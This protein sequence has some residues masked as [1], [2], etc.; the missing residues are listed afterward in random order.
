MLSGQDGVIR[1]VMIGCIPLV[2]Q[3]LVIVDLHIWVITRKEA[4]I[5]VLEGDEGACHVV[6]QKFDCPWRILSES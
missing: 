3:G 4:R 1:G 2:H 6:I 5:A